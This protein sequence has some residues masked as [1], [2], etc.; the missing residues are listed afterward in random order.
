MSKSK[1]THT[2]SEPKSIFA[3]EQNVKMLRFYWDT[4]YTLEICDICSHFRPHQK[5]FLMFFTLYGHGNLFMAG[6]K[7]RLETSTFVQKRCTHQRPK[8]P[9]KIIELR[10][11]EKK[12]GLVTDTFA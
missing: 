1:F 12:V 5:C 8:L 4:R 3:L 9:R 6:P 10:D 11:L 2:L 7:S